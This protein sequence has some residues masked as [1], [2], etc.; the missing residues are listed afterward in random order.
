MPM[1]HRTNRKQELHRVNLLIRALSDEMAAQ[2]A[3]TAAS[4]S[5]G[6]VSAAMEEALY[7]L[8]LRKLLISAFIDSGRVAH[9]AARH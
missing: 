7:Q 3:Q 6:S 9:R 2:R 1:L 5:S 4:E 8:R